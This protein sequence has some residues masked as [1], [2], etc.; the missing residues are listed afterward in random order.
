[1]VTECI[2]VEAEYKVPATNSELTI[3]RKGDIFT[4]RETADISYIGGYE[5]LILFGE[6]SSPRF[7]E[8]E[9][10]DGKGTFYYLGYAFIV[11]LAEVG[12]E[13]GIRVDLD[14]DGKIA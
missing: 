10:I 5:E 9:I 1:M 3:I 4:L 2:Q 8:V 6:T 13:P 12:T 14:G 11:E 7:Y